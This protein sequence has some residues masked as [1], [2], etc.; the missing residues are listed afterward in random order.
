[1]VNNNSD[2]EKYLF[3]NGCFVSRQ[4][5]SLKAPLINDGTVLNFESLENAVKN[6]NWSINEWLN[7]S[8]YLKSFN[9]NDRILIVRM[10]SDFIE[11]KFKNVC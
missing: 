3:D 4:N 10:L 5:R 11:I 8:R 6:S 9:F 2:I 7:Y 1:M